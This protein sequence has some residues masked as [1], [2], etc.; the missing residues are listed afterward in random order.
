MHFR[1]NSKKSFRH[2]ENEKYRKNKEK[3]EHRNQV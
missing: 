3:V 1:S 2:F